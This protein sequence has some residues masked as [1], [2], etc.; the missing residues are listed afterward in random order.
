MSQPRAALAAFVLAAAALAACGASHQGPGPATAGSGAGSA[1]S[2]SGAGAGSS[3]GSAAEAGPPDAAGV[4]VKQVP[5]RDHREEGAMMASVEMG[6]D[7]DSR[8]GPLDVGAD[9]LSY[10]R[11][12]RKPLNIAARRTA[13]AGTPAAS[14]IASSTIESRAPCR[15]SPVTR[16]R[17]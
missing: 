16:P 4:H 3:A 8:F 6:D 17:R 1:G 11:V 10:V 5:P 13:V 2:G 7:P 9:Y 12:T 15:T 14:A